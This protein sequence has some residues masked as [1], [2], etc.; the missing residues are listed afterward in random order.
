MRALL[1]HSPAKIILT[2]VFFALSSYLWRLYITSTISDTFPWGF[3]WQ[4]YLAWGPCPP[5]EAC[6][7][8]K[9][10]FL[11]LNILFW[12]ILSGFLVAGIARDRA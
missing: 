6:S 11:I 4:F 2:L 10:L 12:Y 9:P 3:P 1:R 7:E 5:G 8:S